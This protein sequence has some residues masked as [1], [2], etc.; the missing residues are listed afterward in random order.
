MRRLK[1]FK[2]NKNEVVVCR[3]K[4][5]YLITDYLNDFFFSLQAKNHI[6]SCYN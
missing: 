1:S 5:S 4:R 6:Q 3:L 2:I